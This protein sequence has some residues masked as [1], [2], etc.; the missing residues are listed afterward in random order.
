VERDEARCGANPNPASA[1]AGAEREALENA[2]R[3]KM[4]QLEAADEDEPAEDEPAED[5]LAEEAP[6]EEAL[7]EEELAEEA[8]AGELAEEVPAKEMPAKEAPVEVNLAAFETVSEEELL[9]AIMDTI[10]AVLNAS[11]ADDATDGAAADKVKAAAAA[12]KAAGKRK[13]SDGLADE[14]VLG[15]RSAHVEADGN[16]EEDQLALSQKLSACYAELPTLMKLRVSLSPDELSE[17]DA[18]RVTVAK[19][20][21]KCDGRLTAYVELKLQLQAMEQVLHEKERSL[22]GKK[23]RLSE[24]ENKTAADP[25]LEARIEKLVAKKNDILERLR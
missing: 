15:K 3:E 22:K 12:E 6:A 25:E 24:L 19:L 2:A 20:Q 9:S 16:V 21:P 23:A 8:P 7:A 13:V 5:E 1:R 11:A 18:L 17:L 4:A 10:P 14:S